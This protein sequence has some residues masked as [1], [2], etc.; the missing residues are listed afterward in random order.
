MKMKITQLVAVV[1]ILA[2]IFTVIFHQ[3]QDDKLMELIF[4]AGVPG[5]RGDIVYYF[6][7]ENDGTFIS[8]RG[9]SRFHNSQVRTRI[10]LRWRNREREEI[11]LS[12]ED[13]L[14][15]SRLVER[16]VSDDFEPGALSDATVK[17]IHNGNI[18]ENC[19]LWSRPLVE[20]ER[21][22]FALTPLEIRWN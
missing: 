21:I 5:S 8:Y 17:F 7:V 9:I 11:T 1:L 4:W 13:F 14:R 20:L 10:L 12:E 18:Y 19:G 2:V 15:I 6:I 3:R 16:I 22:L